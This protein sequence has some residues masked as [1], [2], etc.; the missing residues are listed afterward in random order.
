ME[1][2]N[3]RIR[4]DGGRTSR[5]GEA[6]G[7]SALARHIHYL[8]LSKS[9]EKRKSNTTHLKP[10]WTYVIHLYDEFLLRAGEGFF[11]ET[12]I[13]PPDLRRFC[14]FDTHR[15]GSGGKT[16]YSSL[17]L[18]VVDLADRDE[19]SSEFMHF[20]LASSDW[21]LID[22]VRK[23]LID[24]EDSIASAPRPTPA[25][26]APVKHVPA[27]QYP[28]VSIKFPY[29]EGRLNQLRHFHALFMTDYSDRGAHFICYRPRRSRPTE[30][31]K[32]F[33]AIMPPE[34]G[35][36]DPNSFSFS[37]IYRAPKTKSKQRIADGM[38]I[39]LDDG[40]YLV[41][42]QREFQNSKV[43][44][45]PAPRSVKVISLAWRSIEVWERVLS[46]LVLSAND[47]G[48]HIASRIV[49]KAT[50]LDH[51]KQIELGAVKITDL[52]SDLKKDIAREIE[53]LEQHEVPQA[54]FERYQLERS[55]KEFAAM[56][57]EL[58]AR[59]IDGTNNH[60]SKWDVVEGTTAKEPG[61]PG[62]TRNSIAMRL[63]TAF[64]SDGSAQYHDSLGREFDFWT[65]LRFGVLAR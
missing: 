18:F 27:A 64:G 21:D 20:A 30:L 24:S 33:L 4:K 31:M 36:E 3:A 13:I 10:D 6:L 34:A 56:P 60:P 45:E 17:A 54:E 11:L 41:G 52:E 23:H 35:G 46:G 1:I 49:L 26:A 28:E 59:I 51:S 57:R 62:L 2:L 47:E 37:H 19:L 29:A 9:E 38:A 14:Y 40:L 53:Y 39:P 15:R 58:A 8:A 55:D 48:D 42:G 65:S 5:G 12:G 61:Q 32:T 16:F 43:P 50:P 22:A 25:A 7:F 44:A 63:E